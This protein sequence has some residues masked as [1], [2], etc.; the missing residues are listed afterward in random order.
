MANAR[1]TANPSFKPIVVPDCT[2]DIP[3]AVPNVKP[4]KAEQTHKPTR[5]PAKVEELFN[6]C[7]KKIMDSAIYFQRHLL[8]ITSFLYYKKGLKGMI[9]FFLP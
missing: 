4:T 3:S 7:D 5:A 6:V 9:S 1:N 2:R 8:Y